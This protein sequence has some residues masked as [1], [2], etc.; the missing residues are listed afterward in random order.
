MEM[1][2]N[3]PFQELLALVK[4]LSPGQ[5]ERLKQELDSGTQF[6]EE[7]DKFIDFLLNGPVYSKDDIKLIESNRKGIS[8]WR[9]KS[10]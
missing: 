2:F 8:E 9:T 5:R 10:Y 3:I 4:A 6:P 1:R 7:N